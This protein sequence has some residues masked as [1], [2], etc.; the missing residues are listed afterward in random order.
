MASIA[1]PKPSGRYHLW[2]FARSGGGLSRFTVIAFEQ[3]KLGQQGALAAIGPF[4]I[5]DGFAEFP[6]F[7]QPRFFQRV[8]SAVNEVYGVVC[9]FAAMFEFHESFLLETA[10]NMS[11][12]PSTVG[13]FLPLQPS[14][15]AFAQ[16]SVSGPTSA[17]TGGLC[18][19]RS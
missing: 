14:L 6:R 10:H 5:G 13:H 9:R 18:M 15:A 17:R 16:A 3:S 4:P 12:M 8:D 19:R 2:L 1:R 7:V 11:L